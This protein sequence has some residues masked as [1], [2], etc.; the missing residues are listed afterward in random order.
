MSFSQRAEQYDPERESDQA[1]R[2]SRA[3]TPILSELVKVLGPYPEGLRRW[4]VMHAIRKD[5]EKTGRDIPQKFE[6]EIERT[7]RRFCAAADQAKT[8]ANDGGE[9]LFYRPREKAGE[10]WAIIPGRAETWRGPL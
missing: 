7:F 8:A 3:D 5:R 6:D 10:V 4:S 1:V 9:T 2:K